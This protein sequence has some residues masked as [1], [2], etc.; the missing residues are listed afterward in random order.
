MTQPQNP[1]QPSDRKPPT[2]TEEE[3]FF[4]GSPSWVG[5]TGPLL[6]SFAIAALLVVIP[7]ILQLMGHGQWWA[8]A[9][10][11]VLAI[12][13][14][15]LQVLVQQSLR[16]RITNYRIDYQRGLL[17]RQIDS[18]ELWYVDHINFRQSLL[19]RFTGV[20]TIELTTNDERM[21]HLIMHSIPS[22]LQVF[23]HL[24][25]S[26]LAAKRQRGLIELDNNSQS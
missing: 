19:E 26:A 24:K 20:G 6:I 23:E 14:L 1:Q 2:P 11:I 17:T 10:G 25:S 7:I 4:D 5:R 12:I 3:V 18:V 8:I 21:P 9:G 16:Y 22:G 15:M 13:V